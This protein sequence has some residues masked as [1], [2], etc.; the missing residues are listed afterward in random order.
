VFTTCD[1]NYSNYSVSQLTTPCPPPSSITA[2]GITGTSAIINWTAPS[3]SYNS[4]FG[5]TVQYKLST[6][7]TWISTSAVPTTTFTKTLTGLALGKT[8][9]VRVR[10]NGYTINSTYVQTSFSTPC[11]SIPAGLTHT[12][13]TPT[14]G[15]VKWNAVSGAVSYNLQY[16]KS[17]VSTWTTVSGITTN[18][19]N[20]TGLTA[21]TIYNYQLQMI[22]TA[23]STAYSSP[24]SF[25]TYCT[26]SGTNNQEWIDYFKFGTMERYGINPEPGG[27]FNA[28]STYN[29]LNV[30][31]GTS[32]I[33]GI[34]S[35]G[36]SGA[37]SR[38]E[39]YAVY[40]DYNRN[41]SFADA[42]E[43]VAGQTAM[44]NGNYYNFTVNIPLTATPGITAIR[45][46][47][48]RQPTAVAP[49]L[50]GNRGETNDYYLNLV[51]P[52]AFSQTTEPVYVR[53]EETVQPAIQVAPNPSTGRFSVLMPPGDEVA[54]FEILNA[55]GT[56]VQKK[57]MNPV[58]QFNIDITN[59]PNGLYLLR[60]TDHSGRRQV[61]KLLKN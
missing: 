23:G 33:A 24:A 11:N 8:Y 48:L 31:I 27:Y 20:L 4:P 16:K 6:S 30:T 28:A 2:T 46:V 42:G 61:C 10:L 52:S 25:T 15:T 21:N 43:K 47:M 50:T 44:T 38:N 14:S 37:N 35:A 13:V 49:C 1:S 22:C 26:S 34:V 55:S 36:F 54:A 51:A 45:V 53:N 60:V 59:L 5:F 18:S 3:T 29:P 41:G 17:T 32:G 57:M 19:Y 12:T 39:Y 56:V 7:S 58:K 9:D 40:I